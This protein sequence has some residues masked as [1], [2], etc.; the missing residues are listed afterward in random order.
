[1]FE[2]ARFETGRRR[3]GG[4]LVAVLMSALVGVTVGLYPS[5]ARAG[6]DYAAYVESLP[7]EVRNAFGVTVGLGSIQGYL[8]T[9]LYGFVWMLILGI[10][11]AYAAASLVAGDVED[12]SMELLLVNPITRTRVVVGKYLGLLPSVV[13]VNAVGALAVV[14]FAEAVGES[15]TVRALIVLH[16]LFV[17]YH[18]A[19]AAVGLVASASMRTQR[20]AQVVSIAVLFATYVV[21]SLTLD[22]DYEWVGALSLS[23]YFDPGKILVAETIAWGDVGVLIVVTLA[24][25]VLAAE[26]FERRDVG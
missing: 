8:V 3:R 24:L 21:D 20:R 26:V 13:F 17:L 10:Y 4:I 6:V 14:G 9:E 12:G 19:C 22:T 15:V 18:A 11:F 2:I 25:V 7:P 23:R 5:I 16:L 1:M